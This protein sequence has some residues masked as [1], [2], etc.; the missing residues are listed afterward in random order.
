MVIKLKTERGAVNVITVEAELHF[1][2]HYIFEIII[3]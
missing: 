1:L 2:I 3:E